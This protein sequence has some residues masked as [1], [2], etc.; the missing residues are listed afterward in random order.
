MTYMINEIKEEMSLIDKYKLNIFQNRTKLLDLISEKKIVI[1]GNGTS[2][3]ASYLLYL[4]LIKKGYTPLLI[5]GSEI[6][7]IFESSKDLKD[8]IFL[9]FSH[10]GESVDIIKS[11]EFVKSKGGVVVGLSDFDDSSLSKISNIHFNT[12]GGQENSVAATK[13]HM[14]QVLFSLSLLYDDYLSFS[15]DIKNTS[16]VMSHLIED[17][18]VEKIAKNIKNNVMVLGAGI[19]YPLALE[20]SLKLKETSEIIAEAYPPREFLHGHIQ[21]LDDSWTVIVIGNIEN[22]LMNKMKNFD[23][24]IIMINE[25]LVD[26]DLKYNK[27]LVFLFIMQLISFN[28]SL[29]MGKNPDKPTKLTKV[30]K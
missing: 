3:N 7:N 18:N 27:Y 11:A 13:S 12:S 9:L 26:K 16:E 28:K 14:M 1:S 25:S 6:V 19:Y 5:Y 17:N 10:S 29:S 2:Y 24:N 22:E 8:Y 15:D 20:S 30:V 21:L 4:I 23:S